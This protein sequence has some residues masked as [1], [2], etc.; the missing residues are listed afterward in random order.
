[1]NNNQD[2]FNYERYP[3]DQAYMTWGVDED[4]SKV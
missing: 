1:M 3:V 4:Q 2:D